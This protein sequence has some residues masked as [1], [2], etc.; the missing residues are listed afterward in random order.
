MNYIKCKDCFYGNNLYEYEHI[1]A[2]QCLFP[3][4]I[5]NASEIDV[6]TSPIKELEDECDCKEAK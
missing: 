4:T 3:K 5:F 2:T 1:K 6:A